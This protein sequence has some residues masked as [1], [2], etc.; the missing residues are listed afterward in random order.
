MIDSK[1]EKYWLNELE[2]SAIF[3]EKLYRT[4]FWSEELE[5]KIEKAIFLG[6]YSIR[7]LNESNLIKNSL[8]DINWNLMSY[9]KFDLEFSEKQFTNY[10]FLN[11]ESKQINLIKLSNQFIH[12][13]LLYLTKKLDIKT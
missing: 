7:K 11:G 6:F 5:F 10:Q 1:M 3:L 2:E 12:S 8:S 4:K 9:P 13:K